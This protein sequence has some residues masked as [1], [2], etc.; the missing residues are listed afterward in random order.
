MIDLNASFQFESLIAKETGDFVSAKWIVPHDL[1]YLQGHFPD[2]PIVPGVAI[3]DA[4]TEL[5][6]KAYGKD[7]QVSLVKNSKF[8]KPLTP[9]SIIT[10]ECRQLSPQEWTVDWTIGPEIIARLLLII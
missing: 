3:L 2:Q 1:P 5:L 7:N 10:I 4:T 9:G 6:R 8:L